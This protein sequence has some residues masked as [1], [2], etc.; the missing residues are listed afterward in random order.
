MSEKPILNDTEKNLLIKKLK[1]KLTNIVNIEINFKINQKIQLMVATP[2]TTGILSINNVIKVFTYFN[3]QFTHYLFKNNEIIQYEHKDKLFDDA[4]NNNNKLSKYFMEI[5]IEEG[6]VE[7][8]NEI[9]NIREE[10]IGEKEKD[11]KKKKR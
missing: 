3:S 7:N 10:E 1:E 6:N 9:I 2:Y 5:K 11:I 4:Y 8:K